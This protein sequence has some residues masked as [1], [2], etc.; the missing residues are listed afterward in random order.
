LSIKY[1]TDKDILS[2]LEV[3]KLTIDPHTMEYSLETNNAYV[4][5]TY[6]VLREIIHSFETGEIHKVFNLEDVES[7]QPATAEQF[8]RVVG[9]I[10]I[11]VDEALEQEG[12]ASEDVDRNML[13]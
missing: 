3:I 12:S 7:G 2:D 6:I 8:A 4:E 1:E 9:E 11:R 10:K 13:N 5:D